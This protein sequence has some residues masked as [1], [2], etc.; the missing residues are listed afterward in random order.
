[1]IKDQGQIQVALMT[2]SPALQPLDTTPMHDRAYRALRRA[3]MAGV[4]APGETI[5]LGRLA[6]ALG[7]SIMPVREAL[8]RLAAE[9]AVEIIPKRGVRI[10]RITREKYEDLGRVRLELEGMAAEMAAHRITGTELES[11]EVYCAQMN[12]I[13]HD[14]A[15]WQEYVVINCDF[16][17]TVYRSSHSEVLLPLIEILWLQSGPL[18]SLYRE[19]GIRRKPGLHEAI[20]SAL[21]DRDAVAAREAVQA[22]L[23]NGIDFIR[24]VAPF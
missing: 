13:A 22:D 6:K 8:R 17:F 11:L 20:I 16:H 18:L 4:Y 15:R 24:S 9:C 19:R 14:G 21:K 23:W 2:A 3:I 10:P 5:S 7:T 1:M 12:E